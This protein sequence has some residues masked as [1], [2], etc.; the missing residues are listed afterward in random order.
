MNKTRI[1]IL[2]GIVTLAIASL[3]L[4]QGSFVLAFAFLIAVGVSVTVFFRPFFGVLLYLMLLYLRPQDLMPALEK[5]RIMLVLAV[6]IILFFLI[7]KIF[8][9]EEIPILSTRQNL[10]MLLML[11]VVPMS[12]I[13]NFRIGAAWQSF[14]EFLTL[15]LAFFVLVNLTGKNYKSLYWITTI[16]AVMLA[17]NG[18]VQHFRGFD[19]FGVFPK[20]GRIRWVGIFGDPNDFALLLVCSMPLVLFRLFDRHVNL[21]KRVLLILVLVVLFT[22]VHFT[23]SRGGY[24]SLGTVL[25]FFAFKKFGLLKGVVMGGI[26]LALLVVFSPGRMADLD[27]YGM[28]AQGRIIAWIDGLVILKS[29]PIFGIGFGKFVEFH[30]RGAHSAFVKCMAELGLAGYFVWLT[31]IVTSFKDLLTIERYH[32]GTELAK[33]AAIAQ[34]SMVGFLSSAYFLS[35]TYSPIIY[36]LFAITV[37]LAIQA[38]RDSGVIRSGI[39]RNE[40]ILILLVEGFS[41][42]SYKLIAMTY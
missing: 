28:S 8:R 34:V 35:Q 4:V 19:L 24:I 33:Y 22:A 42:L 13:A 31:L 27:P 3:L 30:G 23:D 39:T 15:F 9:K 7:H 18:L 21:L 5:L 32:A 25:G 17:L 26:F 36:I 1:V 10:F 14:N 29:K 41:I 12:H 38:G 20:A 6:F 40:F 16:C 37:V 11:F 2:A